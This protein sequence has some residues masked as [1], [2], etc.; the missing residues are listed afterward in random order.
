MYRAPLYATLISLCQSCQVTFSCAG[1]L[2]GGDMP[3]AEMQKINFTCG[4]RLHVNG[5]EIFDWALAWKPGCTLFMCWHCPIFP[6]L[7]RWQFLSFDAKAHIFR[8]SRAADG[9]H[10]KWETSK[11]GL[12]MWRREQELIPG[13]RDERKRLRKNF[14]WIRAPPLALG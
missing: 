10:E 5:D 14:W 6:A 4:F 3:R 7:Q 8:D 1:V 12:L 2:Q 13:T 9:A 11:I